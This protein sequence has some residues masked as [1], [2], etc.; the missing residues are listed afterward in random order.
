MIRQK[1]WPFKEILLMTQLFEVEG[2][3]IGTFRD[4][5]E[6]MYYKRGVNL[7]F[8]ICRYS[9]DTAGS[10]LNLERFN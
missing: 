1:V 8:K 7:C 10:V 6:K 9:K 5:C 2:G 4:Y 3:H